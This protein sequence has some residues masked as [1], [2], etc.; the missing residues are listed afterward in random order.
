MNMVSFRAMISIFYLHKS[1]TNDACMKRWKFENL[2]LA[3][4]VMNGV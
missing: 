1:E 3:V 4:G 2:L